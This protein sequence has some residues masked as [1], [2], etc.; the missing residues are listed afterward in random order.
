MEQYGS[1]LR[2][3]CKE[4]DCKRNRVSS[5]DTTGGNKDYLLIITFPKN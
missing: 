5:Y 4:R 2:D 3:L 1:S